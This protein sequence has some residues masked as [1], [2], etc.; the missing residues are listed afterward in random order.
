M[1]FLTKIVQFSSSHR[2]YNPNWSDEKNFEVYNKCSNPNGHGHNYKLEVTIKGTP[3]PEKGFIID[4]KM[5]KK[6]INEEIVDKVDHKNLNLDVDFLEG[7]IPTVENLAVVFWKVLANKFP[8][9]ELHKIRIYE[10]CTS[11][12]DYYG[13]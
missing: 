5:M 12:V 9:A 4:L 2:L 11:F 10:T 6:I 7:I 3:D 13:E 8:N 1:L